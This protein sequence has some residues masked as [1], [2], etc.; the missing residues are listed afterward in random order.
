MHGKAK[1]GVR[2]TTMAL[3]KTFCWEPNQWCLLNIGSELVC[4]GPISALL[5]HLRDQLPKP[6]SSSGTQV[7]QEQRVTAGSAAAA[8]GP[9]ASAAGLAVSRALSCV[10]P[11]GAGGEPGAARQGPNCVLRRCGR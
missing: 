1:D 3:A 7:G 10:L 5:Q 4:T 6:D 8:L 2:M 9:A 11:G